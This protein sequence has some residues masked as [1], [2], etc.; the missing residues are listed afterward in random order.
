MPPAFVLSQD[1]TL[2]LTCQ[3]KGPANQRRSLHKH[4][5]HYC[6]VQLPSPI[7]E[8]SPHNPDQAISL[9]LR[10]HA[11]GKDQIPGQTQ[12]RSAARVSLLFRCTCQSADTA[13]ATS[14]TLIRPGTISQYSDA[15]AAIQAF[16]LI[17]FRSLKLFALRAVGRSAF[18]I[19][20]S[21]F[22]AA[23]RRRVGRFLGES[24]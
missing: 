10:R 17:L 15:V 24:I 13:H 5:S 23:R 4:V 21:P 19:S 14:R 1:Q 3:T 11:F 9:F 12:P 7:T 6:P 22:V 18:R 8:F 20:S 2:R 16:E